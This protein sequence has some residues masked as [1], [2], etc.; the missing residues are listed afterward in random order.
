MWTKPNR[1]NDRKLRTAALLFGAAC[2]SLT[3]ATQP[4]ARP[5]VTNAPET[6]RFLDTTPMDQDARGAKSA[7]KGFVQAMASGDADA[8]W[9]FASEEEHDAFQVKNV[10][11][12]AYAEAFPTLTRV[13]EVTVIRA[14]TEAEA[15]FLQL[16]V[17]DRDDRTYLTEMGLWLS[18]AGDWK[19]VS[20]EVKPTGDY[21]AGL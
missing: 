17:R 3:V 8:L 9:M 11:F 6:V 20:L 4:M 16:I 15:E 5:E 10:A 19:L 12:R 7:A 14:W 21:L 2:L 1:T 13:K 18:D